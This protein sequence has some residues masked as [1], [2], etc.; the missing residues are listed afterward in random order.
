MMPSPMRAEYHR[1]ASDSIASTIGERGDQHRDPHDRAGRFRTALGDGVDDA[2]GE[3]RGRDADRRVDDDREQEDDDVAA[4]R[5]GEGQHAPRGAPVQLV[6][7]DL[8]LAADRAQHA[9]AAGV[10]RPAH[11]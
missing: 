3:H 1:W 2:A 4:E 11:P 10:A 6:A 9:R 5:P 7:A 8:I